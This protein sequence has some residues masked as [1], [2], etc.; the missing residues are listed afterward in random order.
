MIPNC[1]FDIRRNQAIPI[2][3]PSSPAG[4]QSRRVGSKLA[5]LGVLGR[6]SAMRTVAAEDPAWLFY[7]SGTTGRPKGATLSHRALLAMTLR[8]YADVDRVGLRDS[9]IHTAPGATCGCIPA[10]SSR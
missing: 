7:T 4:M 9:M 3:V 6:S 2:H 8:Y 1:R 5:S 10:R